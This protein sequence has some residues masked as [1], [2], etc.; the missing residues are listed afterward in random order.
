MIS[1]DEKYL[2]FTIS[3]RHLDLNIRDLQNFWKANQNHS[4][5]VLPLLEMQTC[6]RRN[7]SFSATKRVI[8]QGERI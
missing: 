8:H 4:V 1:Y 3:F 2:K 5:E 6:V 7:Q